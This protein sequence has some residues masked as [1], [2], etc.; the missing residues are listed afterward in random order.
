[1]RSNQFSNLFLLDRRQQ[2]FVADNFSTM[3][4]GGVWNLSFRRYLTDIENF[5]FA[6]LMGMLTKIYLSVD[7][8]DDRLWKPDVKGQFSVKSF[9][10]VSNDMLGPMDGWNSFWDPLV[11]LRV[12][13]FFG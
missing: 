12:L 5:D 4:G 9:Y 10:N 13:A 2:G 8:T 11:P 7:K 1:M 6:V 3:A